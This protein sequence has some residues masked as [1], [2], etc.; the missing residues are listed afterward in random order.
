MMTV[1]RLEVDIPQQKLFVFKNKNKKPIKE[2]LISTAKKGVGQ[3]YGSEQTPQGLHVIRAKIGANYP[4]NTVFIKRRATGELFVPEMRE[5]F[6]ER[7]WILTRIFWLC[8]LE[9]GKNRFGNVD[10]MKRRIYIHGSPD[11]VVM[12]VPGSRGCVR[13]RNADI[14]ELFE[15]IPAG[16]K[17]LIKA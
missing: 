5:Q 12:G 6:P 15:T 9:V 4:A 3:V 16:T 2:Y 17:V 8:G 13:M 10:S 1:F 11:D 14:I 7:D